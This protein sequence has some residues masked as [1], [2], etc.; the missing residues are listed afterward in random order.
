MLQL[1][2][3]GTSIEAKLV[4]MTIAFLVSSSGKRRNAKTL[5]SSQ[6]HVQRYHVI[7]HLG[8]G[9]GELRSR[10][11]T[12][13]IKVCSVKIAIALRFSF[14][15]YAMAYLKPGTVHCHIGLTQFSNRSHLPQ[16]Q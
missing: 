4:L 1:Q 9:S 5:N 8:P 7:R 14:A 10:Q 13:D 6:N 12:R 2:C 11:K 15:L 16:I 3:D